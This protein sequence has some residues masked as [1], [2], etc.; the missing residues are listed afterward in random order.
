MNMRKPLLMLCSAAL[1]LTSC[2]RVNQ[3]THHHVETE[4]YTLT[5]D[6]KRLASRQQADAFPQ[7]TSFLY[8]DTVRMN[9]EVT[10]L[11]Q[12][13]QMLSEGWVTKDEPVLFKGNYVLSL[14]LIHHPGS[15]HEANCTAALSQL[16]DWGYI[17]IDTNHNTELTIVRSGASLSDY[18]DGNNYGTSTYD[19]TIPKE[20]LSD[21]V[22]GNTT[23]GDW[24]NDWFDAVFATDEELFSFLAT[25][26]YDT[27][28][29]GSHTTIHP[30][31]R[32]AYNRK[33]MGVL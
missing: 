3:A 13:L 17:S 1:L 12:R 9:D 14:E 30:H 28:H 11:A 16:R 27:I 26:G 4:T 19:I 29:T 15:D 23:F 20:I 8:G 33:F 18:K 25:H 6:G 10:D 7:D 2:F 5:V 24:F 31:A 21:S 22:E 32:R